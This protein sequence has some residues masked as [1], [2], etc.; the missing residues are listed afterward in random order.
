MNSNFKSVN[1]GNN[2]QMKIDHTD[3]YKD[4]GE[5]F[6]I[7][8]NIDGYHGSLDLLKRIVSPF[9][10]EKINGKVVMEVGSEEEFE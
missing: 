8:S 7:D 1:E 2:S 3:S 5:Q 10:I 4:F 6:V 9:E